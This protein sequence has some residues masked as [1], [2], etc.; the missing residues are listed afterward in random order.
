M[1]LDRQHLATAPVI[2]AERSN[3]KRLQTIAIAATLLA[4]LLPALSAVY[5][6]Y[7]DLND[8]IQ[9]LAG[10]QAVLVGRY[11]SLNPDAWQFKPEHITVSLKGIRP[12]DTQT[13]IV[14][15]GKPIMEIG[16]PV[17][18]WRIER[19]ANFFAF[20]EA[21]QVRVIH[22]VDNLPTYALIVLFFGL[23]STTVMLWLLRHFVMQPLRVANR[24][25]LLDETRLADLV[26]LSSDWFWETD[27]EH[28]FTVNTLRDASVIDVNKLIGKHR[29]DLP[30]SLTHQEWAAHVSELESRHFFTLR[31]AIGTESG[32]HW[33]E[34]RGKPTY[35]DDGSFTGYR[36]VGRDISHDMLR[37]SELLQHRNHLQELVDVQMAD[38][39]RA[40]QAAEAANQAKSEFLANISHEL[41]TPMHGILSFANFGLT[42]KNAT[43]EKI[44][45]YFTHINSSAERLLELLNNLLDLSKLEAGKMGLEFVEHD[46]LQTVQSIAGPMEALAAQK[47][48]SIRIDVTAAD[49][50]IVMDP[51]RI[52]QLIQNLL[53]NALRFSAPGTEIA[54]SIADADLN[55]G[56][57]RADQ[58][59]LPGLQLAVADG[60]PGIPE[61]EL[62]TIFEKFI[63]SSNTKSG[64]GGT[65]LGLAICREIAILHVGEISARNR[66]TGGAEFILLLPRQQPKFERT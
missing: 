21:G 51:A 61:A 41:R 16:E 63:Q 44:R 37:E 12:D 36:G 52:A 10:N 25:R 57:R 6:R 20:G 30:S 62:E 7:S 1:S 24:L 17:A 66:P 4:G 42:K 40:K 18:G 38:V 22:G 15:D 33:F 2:A 5:I 23:T 64:A 54:I 28:R 26:D 45:D 13:L 56:R 50:R 49:T 39:V 27:T 58:Q 14:V 3:L 55:V 32:Q 47:N 53:G 65:G 48:L 46:L 34:I 43:P 31:Y 35:A 8:H 60:G 19:E 59:R 11:A 9:Q 29:W